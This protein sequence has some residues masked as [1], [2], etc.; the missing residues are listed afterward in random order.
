MHSIARQKSRRPR[1]A[2]NVSTTENAAVELSVV[3]AFLYV[4]LSNRKHSCWRQQTAVFLATV[5]TN[6]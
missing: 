1:F 6:V 5:T 2:D 3:D 4:G